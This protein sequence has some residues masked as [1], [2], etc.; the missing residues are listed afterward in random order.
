MDDLIV[1]NVWARRIL[2]LSSFEIFFSITFAKLSMGKF[3]EHFLACSERF[4][5]PFDVL[6][7]NTW[8][9]SVHFT[10]GRVLLLCT[11]LLKVFHI[12][13]LLLTFI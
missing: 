4:E 13:D 3:L 1:K 11:I 7:R 2:Y 5:V 9:H 6:Y 10:K 8:S 12:A